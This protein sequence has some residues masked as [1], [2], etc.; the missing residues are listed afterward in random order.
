MFGEEV[1]ARL[2]HVLNLEPL[3]RPQVREGSSNTCCRPESFKVVYLI[4]ARRRCSTHFSPTV[5][6]E[7]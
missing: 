7:V 3:R 1:T 5:M 4:A 6:W 2:G